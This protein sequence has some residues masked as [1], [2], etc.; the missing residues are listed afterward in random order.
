MEVLYG[1]LREI[2]GVLTIAHMKIPHMIQ[3]AFLA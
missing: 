1:L 3:A 2:L